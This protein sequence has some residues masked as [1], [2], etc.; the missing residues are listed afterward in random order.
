M[1]RLWRRLE[2]LMDQS[3]IA[4]PRRALA[5]RDLRPGDRLQIGPALFRVQ[6]SLLLNSGPLAFRL[7]DLEG[8]ETGPVRLLEMQGTWTLLRGGGRLEV[9]VDCVVHYPVEGT[10]L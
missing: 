2:R 9:P 8:P 4:L 10:R 7:E 5:S 1:R 6:G 3:R